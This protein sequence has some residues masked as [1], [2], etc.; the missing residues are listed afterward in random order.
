[1]H[2]AAWGALLRHIPVEQQ[3][4]YMLVTTAGIE[5]AVQVFL[6]VESE[7]VVFK[8]RLAGSQ[9]QGLLFFMPYERIEYIGTTKAVKDTEVSETFGSLTFP[10]PPEPAAPQV[11]QAPI[12]EEPPAA[13]D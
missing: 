11:V 12:D 9:D 4:G 2:N 1:M 5:I 7:L 3:S 8:G 6:R 13:L 10:E